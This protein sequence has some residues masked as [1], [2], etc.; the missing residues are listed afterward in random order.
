MA[1]SCKTL[2]YTCLYCTKENEDI[3]TEQVYI[4]ISYNIHGVERGTTSDTFLGVAK[5]SG[6]GI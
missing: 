4:Q 3:L 2:M 5:T 1:D 6:V